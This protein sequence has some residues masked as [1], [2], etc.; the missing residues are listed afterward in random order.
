MKVMRKQFIKK[1]NKVQF[2]MMERNIMSRANH[3]HVCKLSFTFQDRT[4]LYLVMELCPGG[5]LLHTIR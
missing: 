5:E 2:V 4:Y 1:E 3:P